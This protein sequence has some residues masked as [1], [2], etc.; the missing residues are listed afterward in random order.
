MPIPECSR[1]A[2]VRQCAEG[3]LTAVPEAGWAE[4]AFG[5]ALRWVHG[6]QGP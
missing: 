6:L 4:D 3:G 5:E 1:A 2:V